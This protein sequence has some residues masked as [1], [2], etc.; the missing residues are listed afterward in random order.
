MLG[1]KLTFRNC[2]LRPAELI[3]ERPQLPE[4]SIIGKPLTGRPGEAYYLIT[5]GLAT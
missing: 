5:I 2:L 1:P 3:A 4:P